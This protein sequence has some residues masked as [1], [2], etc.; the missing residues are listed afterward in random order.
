[1]SASIYGGS[2]T[3]TTIFVNVNVSV[4]LCF[5]LRPRTMFILFLA[6]NVAGFLNF[7]STGYNP[8]LVRLAWFRWYL[9][10]TCLCDE[11]LGLSDD[12]LT[13]ESIN[14]DHA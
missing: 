14:L 6:L 1:M 5:V 12:A 8:W 2:A 9:Y 11:L 10:L 4:I 13:T 3:A 7:S